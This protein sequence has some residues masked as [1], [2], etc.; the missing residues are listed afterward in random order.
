MGL[1]NPHVE[2][3]FLMTFREYLVFFYKYNLRVQPGLPFTWAWSSFVA[4]S[5]AIGEGLLP[6]M[7]DPLYTETKTEEIAKRANATPNIARTLRELHVHPAIYNPFKIFREL[8]LDRLFLL[9]GVLILSIQVY[10]TIYLFISI[11]FWVF[12][13]PLFAFLIPFV[14]YARSVKS[15]VVA[16]QDAALDQVPLLS[17]IANVKRI[18]FGHTHREFRRYI[19]GVEVIN[20]G[21]WSPAYKD[22]E[23]TQ[24]YGRKC[25]A[26]IRPVEGSTVRESALYS[27]EDPGILEI[28]IDEPKH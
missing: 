26:W 3:T 7:R 28:P 12:F 27:W 25:F 18:I 14:F 2:S 16:L 9:L 15:E 6:A 8:W 22:P 13:I 5:S 4:G 19:Q 24:G 23:C 11:P 17:R 21:N 1:F 20:T 10:T